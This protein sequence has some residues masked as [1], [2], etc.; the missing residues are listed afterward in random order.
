MT[1]TEFFEYLLGHA[2]TT[3]LGTGLTAAYVQRV[4]IERPVV[5]RSA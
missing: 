5:A 4:A 3:N 2:T 1:I